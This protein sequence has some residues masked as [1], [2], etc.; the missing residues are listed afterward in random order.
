M[1][2]YQ[3]LQCDNFGNNDLK[4]IRDRITLVNY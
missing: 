4:G 1:S 3:T 2:I